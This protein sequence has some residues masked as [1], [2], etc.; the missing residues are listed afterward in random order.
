[1]I[2]SKDLEDQSNIEIFLPFTSKNLQLIDIKGWKGQALKMDINTFKELVSRDMQLSVSDEIRSDKK[3]M[4]KISNVETQIIKRTEKG[5]VFVLIEKRKSGFALIGQ[6]GTISDK[7]DWNFSDDRWI[8]LR[9]I[10]FFSMKNESFS[11]SLRTSV[12][13]KLLKN[14]MERGYKNFHFFNKKNESEEKIKLAEFQ[15]NDIEV[16]DY[17]NKI[18]AVLR[19]YGVQLFKK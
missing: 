2:E 15:L 7:S 13:A 19:C 1:M 5:T 9:E 6:S 17:F 4:K 14:I 3:L 10:F 18:L 12:E 16:Q 11:L 8:K